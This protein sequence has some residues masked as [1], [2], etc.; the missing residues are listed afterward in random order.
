[1]TFG[2]FQKMSTMYLYL[3]I[4]SVLCIL[5]TFVDGQTKSSKG[6][7]ICPNVTT[8]LS[9]YDVCAPP[10]LNRI[11]CPT[12]GDQGVTVCTKAKCRE[13]G[14]YPCYFDPYC[15]KNELSACLDCPSGHKFQQYCTNSCKNRAKKQK[16]IKPCTKRANAKEN[17]CFTSRYYVDYGHG[18]ACDGVKDC[19]GGKDELRCNSDAQ[20]SKQTE[21]ERP[22]HCPN[23]TLC[24]KNQDINSK[25]PYDLCKCPWG[26]ARKLSCTDA[27]CR[28]LPLTAEEKDEYGNETYYECPG[29]NKCYGGWQECDGIVDCP[30]GADE[31][32][33]SPDDCQKIGKEKCPGEEKCIPSK[34]F[35]DGDE[36]PINKYAKGYLK[37]SK[38]SNYIR[39]KCS[40]NS[41]ES[42]DICS[43]KCTDKKQIPCPYALGKY[44]LERF[45][46]YADT[47]MCFLSDE[48]VK[49][50]KLTSPDGSNGQKDGV[51]ELWRCSPLRS[52][53]ILRHQVCDD[54]FDCLLREDESEKLCGSNWMK[55]YL[56][57]LII[58]IIFMGV[59]IFSSRY[60]LFPI[61]LDCQ[62][63]IDKYKLVNTRKVWLIKRK[64]LALLLR[65]QC[66]EWRF[67]SGTKEE[68][69]STYK[70]LHDN[71]ETVDM[72]DVHF[73]L[74]RR[75]Q[76]A[77]SFSVQKEIMEWRHKSVYARIFNMELK[78]HGHNVTEAI[79]CLK[80][81]LQTTAESYAVLDYK[82]PP[83]MITRTTVFVTT[84][85]KYLNVH[86]IMIPFVR[87]FLFVMDIIKDY[88][89][90]ELLRKYVFVLG[91]DKT[92]Y[93]DYYLFLIAVSSL[94]IGHIS[95][96]CIII[97][98][99]YDALS[100]CA[101]KTKGFSN[102]L[103][104]TIIVLFF[105]LVG[106]AMAAQ[107]YIED[108]KMDDDFN[109]F[110]GLQ[111][112]A[113]SVDAVPRPIAKD[114]FEKLVTKVNFIQNAEFSGFA[115]IKMVEC[116]TEAYLQLLLLL[117]MYSR[118]SYDGV[119]N[120]ELFGSESEWT[121][122]LFFY[123]NGFW[124]FLT[125]VMG[126][127][128][129][130]KEGENKSFGIKQMVVLIMIYF[131]QG[132]TSLYN[133]VAIMAIRLTPY[134]YLIARLIL[135]GFYGTRIIALIIYSLLS[136]SGRKRAPTENLYF[137]V[138][139]LN[140]PVH[141][142]PFQNE[143]D[144]KAGNIRGYTEFVFVWTLNII[145]N[146]IKGGVILFFQSD[147]ILVKTLLSFRK[148]DLFFITISCEALIFILISVYFRKCYLWKDVLFRSREVKDILENP[149]AKVKKENKGD[150]DEFTSK[151]YI[152]ITPSQ[153]GHR[154]SSCM[155]DENIVSLSI[156]GDAKNLQTSP[157]QQ[158]S[159]AR[160]DTEFVSKHYKKVTPTRMD[161]T[162]YLP[163]ESND[164]FKKEADENHQEGKGKKE[165]QRGE[166]VPA[167]WHKRDA[168]NIVL[169]V[170]SMLVAG[171]L[172]FV[173][174]NYTQP[175]PIRTI[176]SDCQ[177]VFAKVGFNGVYEITSS[178]EDS[179]PKFT[180]C[181]DGLTLVQKTDP[182]SGNHPYYFER[183]LKSFEKGFGE[184][185]REYWIGLDQ[186]VHL[187]Q[188]Q[189]NTFLRIEG[190]FHNGTEFWVEYDNFN[191]T[192]PVRD[193]FKYQLAKGEQLERANTENYSIN[194][195]T[196]RNSSIANYQ[197]V[198][199]RPNYLKTY[200][201]KEL[202]RELG[203]TA[204]KNI[205][206]RFY[207]TFIAQVTRI[208]EI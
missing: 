74:R 152:K 149:D 7:W 73:F 20:C 174:I 61:Q 86:V 32:N 40:N 64:L 2:S 57:G 109:H 29:E 134:S 102:Y 110:R 96:L 130:I 173:S 22:L 52:Q 128:G 120:F 59:K 151:H 94:L 205:H 127:V 184:T 38:Y 112:K 76:S 135:L 27:I 181:Q 101:H 24:I 144:D 37:N 129:F 8:E 156:D 21:N 50:S 77:F 178:S 31:S 190:T 13:L 199:I 3:S 6:L 197:F 165:K 68:L 158:K 183:S 83:T 41:D 140:L 11:D 195:M 118:D 115:D 196:F 137:M 202:D 194:S 98:S 193:H 116:V 200:K 191:I 45:C 53:W 33:C 207:S 164:I 167:N 161:R 107:K 87:A 146:L 170:L 106:I 91:K 148:L 124:S 125:M 49:T 123:V 55:L 79:C 142:G 18:T 172:T 15:V 185:S 9:I 104:T 160:K 180:F 176:Y 206:D 163:G 82:E 171:L 166:H 14:L 113:E 131:I 187:N 92:T 203:V 126:L 69:E 67:M 133:L 141:F 26:A 62:E 154:R 132:L 99:R 35:C 39:N 60:K 145:D 16:P 43:K 36:G 58:V 162:S 108:E 19:E 84:S 111:R 168:L 105:P 175:F 34:Y 48:V 150:I 54:K 72:R 159:L 204:I 114:E 177:D 47:Q 157:E 138:A 85:M 119:I 188:K 81:S 208:N 23:S 182:K 88:M 65:K 143:R 186:M 66:A 78:L 51:S 56:L 103:L 201:E 139:N 17:K 71:L 75:V 189:N 63:C 89:L 198:L 136:T 12:G 95:V 122:R 179:D 169:I 90:V 30:S 147:E 70:L 121:K 28:G 192:N 117:V 155:P 5:S 10:K 42:E 97:P 4:S 46:L 80:R 153:A 93:E 44:N 1:M 100:I 25:I